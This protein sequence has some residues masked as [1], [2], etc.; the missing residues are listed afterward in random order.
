MAFLWQSNLSAHGGTGL[1]LL[2]IMTLSHQFHPAFSQGL[3][4][5]SW[6]WFTH[7]APKNVPLRD[8]SVSSLNGMMVVHFHV[9]FFFLHIIFWMDE[10]G[11]FRHQ[12][13]APKAEPH[14]WSS[15]ILFLLS[16]LISLDFPIM[17]KKEAL[18]LRCPFIYIH[19]CTTNQ[20][21]WNQLTYQKLLKLR[22]ES[23]GGFC[24]KT[25]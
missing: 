12:E 20:C 6:G 25:Q 2:W 15:T 14:L 22:M 23:S 7:F 11:T 13:I 18:C 16:W 5:S 1:V 24:L 4:L 9:F 19:R 3:L 8:L 10:R 21:K 17:S